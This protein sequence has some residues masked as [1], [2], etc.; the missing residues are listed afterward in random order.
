MRTTTAHLES[1][2]NSANAM[3]KQLNKEGEYGLQFCYGHTN[4][5][6][7]ADPKSTGCS[8]VRCGLSK[9]EAMDVLQGILHALNTILYR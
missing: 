4:I 6:F 7:Y 8:D 9:G 1:A 5:V 2:I 3:L